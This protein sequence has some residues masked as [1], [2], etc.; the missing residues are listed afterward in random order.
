MHR[1]RPRHRALPGSRAGAARAGCCR[2]R[3]RRAGGPCRGSLGSIKRAGRP[4]AGRAAALAGCGQRAVVR[5]GRL[6]R[7]APAAVK[8]AGCLAIHGSSSQGPQPWTVVHT[9]RPS[10][11][12]VVGVSGGAFE[13]HQAAAGAVAAAVAAS[14]PN[15][16]LGSCC[17]DV[18]HRHPTRTP[19]L[20]P[21]NVFRLPLLSYVL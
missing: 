8:D 7:G 3:R 13:A 17:L 14:L 21:S 20:P 15:P 11:V 1:H 18:R 16:S 12:P 10:C 4:S 9:R 2:L 19:L 5:H 6:R